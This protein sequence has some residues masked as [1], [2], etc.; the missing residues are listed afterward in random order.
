L[1]ISDIALPGMSGIE[2]IRT[3]RSQS[4]LLPVILITGRSEAHFEQD[5][6]DLGVLRLFI[7]PFDTAALLATL[8]ASLR[9]TP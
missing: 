9:G 2:L 1:L 4:L 7:K 5:A 3:L 8:R 6:R